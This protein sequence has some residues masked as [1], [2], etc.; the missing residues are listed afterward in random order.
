VEVRG[1]LFARNDAGVALAPRS[2]GLTFSANAFIGNHDPVQMRGT[3][4]DNN[5]WRGNYWS[6]ALV[7]DR[8]GDGVSELPYRLESSYEVLADRHPTLAFFSNTP[9]ADALDLASRLFPLFAPRPRLTDPAPLVR[10]P[11]DDWLRGDKPRRAPLVATG[12]MLLL[13]AAAAKK[14]LA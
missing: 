7:Y 5:D 6:D 8:D 9:A 2:Q 11:L 4:E 10:P 1:N 13:L 14:V 3:G 12:A